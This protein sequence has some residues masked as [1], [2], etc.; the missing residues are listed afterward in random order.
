MHAKSLSPLSELA[1]GPELLYAGTLELQACPRGHPG[2]AG[3]AA[4]APLA[5]T[6]TGGAPSLGVQQGQAQRHPAR[7]RAAGGQQR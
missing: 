5:G 4:A 3:A 2:G 7:G 1:A 6:V